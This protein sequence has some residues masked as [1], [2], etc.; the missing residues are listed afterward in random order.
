MIKN[1][2]CL[3]NPVYWNEIKVTYYACKW[4][5]RIT[6]A[7]CFIRK[8]LHQDKVI[9]KYRVGQIDVF[10]ELQNVREKKVSYIYLLLFSIDVRNN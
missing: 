4:F 9:N 1:I 6:Q 2:E 8:W 10:K 7:T 5:D 3:Q